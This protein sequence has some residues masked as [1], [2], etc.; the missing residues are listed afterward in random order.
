[1]SKVE[2]SERHNA[3]EDSEHAKLGV[4][5]P[6]VLVTRV[7]EQDTEPDMTKC[8]SIQSVAV[9]ESVVPQVVIQGPAEPSDLLNS[10]VG[11]IGWDLFVKVAVRNPA[12]REVAEPYCEALST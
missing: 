6:F 9:A 11:R 7:Q 1:M 4:A 8:G 12:V 3:E 10:S 5:G 2:P